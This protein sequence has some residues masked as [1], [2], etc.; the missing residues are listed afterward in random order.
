MSNNWTSPIGSNW[1]KLAHKLNTHWFFILS[2]WYDYHDL[3]KIHVK[4]RKIFPRNCKTNEPTKLNR[5]EWSKNSNYTTNSCRK[6]N[7]Q[8]RIYIY[9]AHIL[10]FHFSH[11]K[12]PLKLKRTF[13]E[14]K[15]CSRMEK[16]QIKMRILIMSKLYAK[17]CA[18][19]S[20]PSLFCHFSD[21][22]ASFLHLNDKWHD[23]LGSFKECRHKPS[24]ISLW[25]P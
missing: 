9:A 8:I 14:C 2:T 1:I 6:L 3:S 12:L 24:N 10:R 16:L 19:L 7:N 15:E 21:E 20:L 25:S 23:N 5:T 11:E 4:I 17:V 22:P 13:G 18:F